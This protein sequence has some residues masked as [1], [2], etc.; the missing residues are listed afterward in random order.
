[1][2]AA[3]ALLAMLLFA[4]SLTGLALWRCATR[5][6]CPLLAMRLGTCRPCSS[7]CLMASSHM[8]SNE[9]LPS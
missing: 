9:R 6:P 8:P 4:T 7:P 5:A 2:R 3:T 1:M